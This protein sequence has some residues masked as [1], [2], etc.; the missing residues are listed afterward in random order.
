MLI[1]GTGQISAR[2]RE[3][4]R[5][6]PE[7]HVRHVP[8]SKM[9]HDCFPKCDA[10]SLESTNKVYRTSKEKVSYDDR[11]PAYPSGN[12]CKHSNTRSPG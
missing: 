11:F 2:K 6:G 3:H 7:P 4:R 8:D 9:A 5:D 12:R 1:A 10:K